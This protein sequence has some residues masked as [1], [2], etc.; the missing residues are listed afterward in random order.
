MLGVLEEASLLK[1]KRE[2]CDSILT[3]HLTYSLQWIL[4]LHM[5]ESK[6]CY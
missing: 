2:N 6:I 5:G 3:L 4:L 1:V